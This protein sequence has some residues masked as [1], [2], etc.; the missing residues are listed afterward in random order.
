MAVMCSINKYWLTP[1]DLFIFSVWYVCMWE[2]YFY[3]M[4]VVGGLHA[5]GFPHLAKNLRNV[6]AWWGNWSRGEG[7]SPSVR[8]S[9]SLS[10]NQ[11]QLFLL[12]HVGQSPSRYLAWD[13][14]VATSHIDGRLIRLPVV[15]HPADRRTVSTNAELMPAITPLQSEQ[16]F[17]V[18]GVIKLPFS[19]RMLM[20]RAAM[21]LMEEY[22]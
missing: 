4:S 16:L 9:L 20:I 8:F 5:V 1:M 13:R 19:V 7:V 12:I 15:R 14:C 3:I 10:N 6:Y 18:V 2:Q 22:I 17:R 11:I 21:L